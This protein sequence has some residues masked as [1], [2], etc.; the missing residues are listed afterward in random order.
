MLVLRP[1]LMSRHPIQQLIAEARANEA[2][3]ENFRKACWGAA[4][5][6]LAGAVA[7]AYG[8]PRR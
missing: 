1:T 5:V 4:G 6:L 3:A 7:S 2:A 8:E